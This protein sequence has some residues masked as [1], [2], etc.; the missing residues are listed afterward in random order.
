[1]DYRKR[2]YYLICIDKGF[3]DEF[4]LII[5]NTV[6]TAKIHVYQNVD[7]P[8]NYCKIMISCN[9]YDVKK[10]QSV[11]GTISLLIK[12]DNRLWGRRLNDILVKEL[13]KQTLGQ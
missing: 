8:E 7:I 10:L 1:M 2:N 9:F 11:L 6:Y 13:T 4:I 12:N 3:I 5:K